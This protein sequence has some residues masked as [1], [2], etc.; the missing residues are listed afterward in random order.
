MDLFDGWALIKNGL[1][2]S[3][4]KCQLFR[5]ELQYMGNT[6]LIKDGRVCVKLLKSRLE[7]IQKLKSP[8]TVKG[9]RSFTCMVN[10]LSLFCL[11]LKKLFKPI[12]DVTRKGR[13]FI[14][15]EEHQNAF[16]EIKRLLQKP[17]ILYILDNTGRFH[18]YSDTSK[19]ATG[20]TLYQIENDKP[21]LIACV[22]KSLPAAALNY[23]ITESELYG[24]VINIVSFAHL[25]KKV[26]LV[27]L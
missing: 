6:I 11:E 27:L 14:W 3:P 13:Q 10:F 12:F 5:K 25:L 19:F 17:P 9:S 2:I 1:K 7:A 18:L 16:D 26:D 8:T 20:S 4:K 22:S 23:S 24:L 21:N 15:G